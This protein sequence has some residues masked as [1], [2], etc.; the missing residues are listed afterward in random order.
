MNP[1]SGT[2][3]NFRG[4]RDGCSLRSFFIILC[5]CRNVDT[6]I[7]CLPKTGSD[8]AIL[9]AFC[10]IFLVR[11]N[12][13]LKNGEIFP[14]S[15][16]SLLRWTALIVALA[17]FVHSNFDDA[18]NGCQTSVLDGNTLFYPIIVLFFAGLYKIAYL[19]AKDSSLAI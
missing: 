4:F 12:R 7:N 19:T 18:I 13:S 15:N 11:T 6:A 10:W 1:V 17:T 9:Y 2:R 8:T 3:S 16:V 5:F 14:R